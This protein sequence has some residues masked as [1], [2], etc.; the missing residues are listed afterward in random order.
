MELV[1]LYSVPSRMKFSHY[2]GI[3]GYHL[4]GKKKTTSFLYST[5]GRDYKAM[6]EAKSCLTKDFIVT[7]YL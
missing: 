5:L 6:E 1:P 7:L 4:P 3:R 2:Q